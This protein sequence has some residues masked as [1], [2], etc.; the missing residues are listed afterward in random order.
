MSEPLHK[1]LPIYYDHLCI[2]IT[3]KRDV[4]DWINTHANNIPFRM[5]EY[6]EIFFG[7]NPKW[8]EYTVWNYDDLQKGRSVT[9]LGIEIGKVDWYHS[10]PLAN[11]PL[12][13]LR[14]AISWS[15]EDLT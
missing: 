8:W 10:E 14:P 6:R 1:M 3:L 11:F 12:E 15:H 5:A 4:T 7:I 2:V 13:E 9:L